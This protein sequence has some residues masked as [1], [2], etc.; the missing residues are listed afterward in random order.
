LNWLILSAVALLSWGFWA[1]LNKMALNY[2]GWHQVYIVSIFVSLSAMLIIYALFKPPIDIQSRG[3]SL[4]ILA[5]I[6]GTV[7]VVAFYAALEGGKA[8]V[9]VPF[10][11]LYPVVAIVLSYIVLNEK[12]SATQGLGVILAVV[13]IILVSI[14]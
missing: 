14:E 9:V 8:S 5:S 1:L 7:A 13:A 11:S 12:L 6:L 10:T 2:L 3:F 4:A